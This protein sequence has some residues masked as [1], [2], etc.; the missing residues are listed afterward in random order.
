MEHISDKYKD[1]SKDEIECKLG[2]ILQ[3]VSVRI[4]EC[5][6]N[7]V[8]LNRCCR[9][10]RIS[11]IRLRVNRPVII[12]FGK[13]ELVCTEAIV[14]MDDI[15]Q[16]LQ[17]ISD[18]S[19]YAHE[20]DV[21][22]G[23]ITLKGGHRAGV[24]GQA[25][26]NDGKIINQKNIGFIN[27]RVAYEVKGCA[28][29]VMPFM[30][31]TGQLEHT[32][33]ISPPACG[34]TTL[35]RDVIRQLSDGVCVSV[36]KGIYISETNGGNKHIYKVGLVD[37]RSE[38]AACYEGIPQNDIGQRTDVAD[39]ADKATGMMMLLRSMSPDVIAVDEL[40]GEN[41]AKAVRYLFGCGC[42][43][44]ATVHGS[45]YEH[46]KNQPYIGE[47]IGEYGFKRIVTLGRCNSSS[48]IENGWIKELRKV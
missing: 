34:K 31:E 48:F 8:R 39:Q 6:K 47:L 14:S 16:S 12:M 26:V 40:A 22:N 19:L 44:I 13:K 10:D 5:L 7:D 38:I 46:V 30:L 36:S 32:L 2:E 25:I 20:K 37:E 24:T 18:Y 21:G 11:E 29:P 27:I 1:I 35:L 28:N 42:K 33:I 9:M 45:D 41:D 3:F 15:R 43:V 23:F 17:F 4:R